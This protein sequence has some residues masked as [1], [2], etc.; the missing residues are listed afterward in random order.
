MTGMRCRTTS[1]RSAILLAANLGDDADTTAA[2][3]GQ[4]AGALYGASAIPDAWLGKLAWRDRI[5]AAAR[6][7]FQESTES[8][9]GGNTAAADVSGTPGNAKAKRAKSRPGP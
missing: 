7:L 5:D 9:Q 2:V 6:Q 1:F 8:E 4:L 3:T